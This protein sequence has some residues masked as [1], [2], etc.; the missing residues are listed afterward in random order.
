MEGEESGEQVLKTLEA[1]TNLTSLT[2]NFSNEFKQRFIEKYENRYNAEGYPVVEN[3]SSVESVLRFG[4]WKTTRED[5]QRVASQKLREQDESRLEDVEVWFKEMSKFAALAGF[6]PGD[7]RRPEY[8]FNKVFQEVNGDW[9][10]AQKDHLDKLVRRQ[11]KSSGDVFLYTQIA[12]RVRFGHSTP[13]EALAILNSL[14]ESESSTR[15][16]ELIEYFTTEQAV[17]DL[18]GGNDAR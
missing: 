15:V 16:K 6:N 4:G 14:P 11:Q 8:I 13:K 1:F 9:T 10:Q 2:R 5:V 12:N 7:P 18:I 3:I 17:N